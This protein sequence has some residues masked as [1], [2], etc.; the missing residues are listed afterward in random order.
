MGAAGETMLVDSANELT[1]SLPEERMMQVE[2]GLS[3][4]GDKKTDEWA[5]AGTEN[6]ASSCWPFPNRYLTRP[7]KEAPWGMFAGVAGMEELHSVAAEDASSSRTAVVAARLWWRQMRLDCP[8]CPM[9]PIWMVTIAYIW[10]PPC[11]ARSSDATLE[12]YGQQD[13]NCL[14]VERRAHD[15]TAVEVLAGSDRSGSLQ[16]WQTKFAAC[17]WCVAGGRPPLRVEL[18]PLRGSSELEAEA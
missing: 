10:H 13:A 4:E 3:P 9:P 5:P 2:D 1:L 11:H 12:V 8:L 18:C 6:D 14:S 7:L 15:C 16:Q 17:Q